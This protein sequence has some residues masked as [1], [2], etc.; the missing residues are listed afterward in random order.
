MIKVSG[1]GRSLKCVNEHAEY[2][3]SEGDLERETDEGERLKG[4]DVAQQLI[5]DWDLDVIL[6]RFQLA[7]AVTNGRK[8]PRLVPQLRT[9]HLD[10][11]W[12]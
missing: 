6:H 7:V 2:I 9:R 11:N 3:G 8:P 10:G 5:E 1:G 12:T 4:D